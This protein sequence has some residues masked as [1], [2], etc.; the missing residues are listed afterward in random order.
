MRNLFRTLLSM[1][2]V[3]SIST[4]FIPM[5]GEAAL[6]N[7]TAHHA[8]DFDVAV[9]KIKGTLEIKAAA[10]ALHHFNLQAPMSVTQAGTSFTQKPS[11]A[12]DHT[13]LFKIKNMG[14]A[15]YEVL[16]F[17]CDD[18]KTY[19]EKHKVSTTWNG[20]K[21][22]IQKQKTDTSAISLNSIHHSSKQSLVQAGHAGFILNRPEEALAEARQKGKPLLIDFFGIWCPPCNQ[23]DEIVFAS[24]EFEK[25]SAGFVKLKLDSDSPE[26]WDLKTKYNVEGYPTVIFASPDGKELSRIVGFRNEQVFFRYM[27]NA[28]ASNSANHESLVSPDRALLV[29]MSNKTSKS[30]EELRELIRVA[31]KAVSQ[32]ESEMEDDEFTHAD[33]WTLIAGSYKELHDNKNSQKAWLKAAAEFRKK[34]K[35][36]EERGFNLEL[37]HCLWKGGEFTAADKIYQNFEKLYPKEFTFYFNHAAMKMAQSKWSE[38]EA[39]A[40]RALEFS[41]GDNKLRA[42]FLLAKTLTVQDRKPEAKKL[43]NSVLNSFPVPKDP[44]IRT[45]RYIKQLRELG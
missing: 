8:P 16:L 22:E 24:P 5:N 26:S 2:H 14:S 39:L 28:T 4:F 3:L 38:T 29:Q 40:R 45:H 21:S 41:Y 17:L 7:K 33:L 15:D 12:H 34:I 32:P 10:P 11:E 9:K 1:V 23:L 20:E 42:A 30:P 37:A 27:K 19:C 44:N 31:T 35:S 36:G 13:V 43:I 18:A 25:Q 6:D